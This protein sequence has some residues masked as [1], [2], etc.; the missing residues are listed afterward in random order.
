MGEQARA[1]PLCILVVEDEPALR[2]TA[3]AIL[4]DAGYA[5]AEAANGDEALAMIEAEPARFSHLF[6]DVEMPGALDGLKLASLVSTL[7]PTMFVAVTSGNCE[8][9]QDA[10]EHYSRFI[11]K[12]WTTTDVLNLVTPSAY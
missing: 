11:A 6:T 9:D 8:A 4:E 5:V 3:V 10:A 1:R 12:P 7:F 2:L